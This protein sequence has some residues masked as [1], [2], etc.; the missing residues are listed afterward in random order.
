MHCQN[1]LAVT[2]PIIDTRVLRKYQERRHDLQPS[3]TSKAAHTYEL[4]EPREL[5]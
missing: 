1:G 4:H 2:A 5:R 3:N